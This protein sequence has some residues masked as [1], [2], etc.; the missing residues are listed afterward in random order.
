MAYWLRRRGPALRWTIVLIALACAGCGDSD[1]DDD[2][3]GPGPPGDDD[4]DA[5]P[6]D[7]LTIQSAFPPVARSGQPYSFQF[8]A[9]GGEPPYGNWRV[10]AGIAPL[11]LALDPG[12][13]ELSGTAANEEHLYYFVVAVSD[14]SPEPAQARESFGIRVGDD[15]DA[16]GPLLL[17]ARAYQE[18]YLERHNC[19][20]LSVSAD[21]PDDPDG[22]Y[23][24]TDLGDACFIHG[25]ASAGAA[26]RYAVE[27]T[28]EA[29]E[30]AGLHAR[31]LDLL[32]RVNGIPGLLSRS[33]MPVDAPMGP[34][35]FQD[36]WPDSENHRGEGEFAGYYWKGDVSIDQ[37]S[38]ALVGLALLYDLVPD[39]SVRAVVRRNIVEI[40]DYLW[41]GGLIVYD[42]DGEPTT[43]G[44][45]RGEYLEYNPIPDGLGAAA[46][47]AW[48]KLAHHAS[49]ERRFRDRYVHLAYDRGYPDIIGRWLVP[50]LGYELTKHY[51]VYMAF[52]NLYALTRLEDD[53]DLH[54]AYSRAFAER[55]WESTGNFLEWRRGGVEANPTFTPWYLFSTER[56]DADAIMR[57]IWQLDVFVEPPL[58]D[59]FIQNSTNP[60]IPR[61]PERPT[62]ALYPLPA[63]LRIPDM[64]I[65]H[66][67]PYHLDGGADN[68]RERTGH[69]YLLPYWMGRYY[70]YIG[71][72]W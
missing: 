34:G 38:G 31:G 52:E 2:D 29:L 65:W 47:L 72:D 49:G 5:P 58:R 1:G 3:D 60:L 67:S 46:S 36:F 21:N 45:F 12:T 17:K 4:D 70:G 59:R 68:G 33:Y 32:N 63:D 51:N 18:V 64:C 7:P 54:A 61:N 6:P 69:D 57:C 43:Y 13:G 23:W 48:F 30:N 24:Y 11:G 8:E 14:S 71:P 56:R 53:P 35:E 28:G 50:Y 37:Y 42:W 16:P 10:A 27:G 22:D 26:F 15:P 25:N 55:L 44:D 20:G 40:A 19:D 62:D 39:E 9:E 66:R 41:D